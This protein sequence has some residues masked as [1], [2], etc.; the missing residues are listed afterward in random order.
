MKGT[1]VSNVC[2]QVPSAARFRVAQGRQ[3]L[4]QSAVS[5]EAHQPKSHAR[6]TEGSTLSTAL[7][8]ARP[9]CASFD[10]NRQGFPALWRIHDPH[11]HWL[12]FGEALNPCGTEDRNM[13]EHILA[14]VVRLD[15]AEA[16]VIIEPLH[17][18]GYRDRR[19]WVRRAPLRAGRITKAAGRRRA[20]R[21]ASRVNLDDAR[22][23]GAFYAIADIHLQ[24]CT[25][26]NRLYPA[27]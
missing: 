3:N 20:F 26:R 1:I 25:G 10:R 27:A 5:R 17:D 13:D 9:N 6:G 21:G 24:L 8:R 15:E 7:A 23:L 12:A 18:P 2:S 14:A 22:D 19:G 16:L 11:R 4:N